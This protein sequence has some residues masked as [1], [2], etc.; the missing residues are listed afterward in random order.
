MSNNCH[1][2]ENKIYLKHC[3]YHALCLIAECAFINSDTWASDTLQGNVSKLQLKF[4]TFA[5]MYFYVF[6][7][8]IYMYSMLYMYGNKS[9]YMHYSP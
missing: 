8:S 2:F 5:Q 7:I 3:S 6:N 4:H 9:V 1:L